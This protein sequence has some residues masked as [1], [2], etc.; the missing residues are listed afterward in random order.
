MQSL[1]IVQVVAHAVPVG[2]HMNGAHVTAEGAT[3][4]PAPLHVELLTAEFVAALHDPAAQVVPFAHSSQLRW[5]SHMPS[6]WQVDF[7][8]AVHAG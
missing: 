1:F 2:A 8:S 6:C 3:Q 5:P 7:A 4:L